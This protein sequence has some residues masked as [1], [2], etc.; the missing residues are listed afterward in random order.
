MLLL[1]LFQLLLPPV[2]GP[3]VYCSLALS[4]FREK[5][6][7][8]KDD[9][10]AAVDRASDGN[11]RLEGR[12]EAAGDGAAASLPAAGDDDAAVAADELL[13]IIVIVMGIDSSRS[14]GRR[15][16]VIDMSS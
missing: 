9:A 15:M 6:C 16:V 12:G 7:R 3:S 11:W 2:E 14:C 13:C 4:Y 1:L 10:A 8:C 5:Y